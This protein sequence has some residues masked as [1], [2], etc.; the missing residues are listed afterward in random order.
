MTGV[1]V[2]EEI[3][4]VATQYRESPK[5]LGLIRAY[6]GQVEEAIQVACSVPSFFDLDTAVG[7]QLTL[8]GKRLGFPRCHCG[9]V[10]PPVIGFDCDGAYQGPYT[11]VGAC[12]GGSLLSCRETGSSTICIDDDDLYRPILKARRYQMLGLYDIDSLNAAAELI[13]GPT[14]SAHTLGGGVV[15][16]APGRELTDDEFMLRPIAF[17]AL[18]IAPGIKAMTSDA[19]G[20]I[21]GFGDGWGGACDG[22]E[23]LC[24]I[25]PHPYDCP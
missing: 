7:D 23:I 16:V 8:L 14:A 11:I 22:S 9:C 2:E 6:L 1:L 17:R 10:M 25:D 19:A 24:P 15:A 20:P 5:L 18:P 4:R 3:D 12:E 13:W 21:V